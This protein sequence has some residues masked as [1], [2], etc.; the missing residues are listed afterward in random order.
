MFPTRT[1]CALYCPV[2]STQIGVQYIDLRTSITKVGGG[3]QATWNLNCTASKL[4][5]IVCLMWTKC[6]KVRLSDFKN[7]CPFQ[8]SYGF[9]CVQYYNRSGHLYLALIKSEVDQERFR[10]WRTKNLE[11]TRFNNILLSGHCPFNIKLYLRQLCRLPGMET[12]RR[13]QQSLT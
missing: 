13:L 1:H 9:V 6:L 7:F 5:M 10:V 2:S 12:A 8:V 4:V 11:S 3:F